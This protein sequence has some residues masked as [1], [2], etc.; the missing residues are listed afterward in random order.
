MSIESAKL[1][2]ER[3][4]DD[5]AF[6]NK[7]GSAEDK[8]AKLAIVKAA[9]FDFTKQEFI[10]ATSGLDDEMLDSVVGGDCSSDC[11]V[12]QGCDACG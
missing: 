4:K 3:M 11:G 10:E 8:D 1:L 6:R 5:K 2:V 9:G 7:V 12:S